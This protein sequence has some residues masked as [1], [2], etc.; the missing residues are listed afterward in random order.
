MT[1]QSAI[2][3][4]Q[5]NQDALRARGIR[6]AALFGSVARGEA[7]STSDVDVLIELD[8]ALK[9]DVFAY[10]GLKRFVAELFDGPVDVVN[11]AALKPYLRRPVA[12]DA[13][14]AF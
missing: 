10:A 2:E 11:K 4:L 14:Y 9:L 8:P 12:A 13:V 3:I 1:R 5:Q 6:H 7:R